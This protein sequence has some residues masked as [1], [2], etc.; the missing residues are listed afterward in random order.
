MQAAIRRILFLV[1]VLV[2]A[3]TLYALLPLLKEGWPTE[4]PLYTLG[5][6]AL[7]LALLVSWRRVHAGKP[8]AKGAGY[9]IGLALVGVPLLFYGFVGLMLAYRAALG[10]LFDR[11]VAITGYHT[12]LI[13]WDGFDGPVGVRLIVDIDVPFSMQGS[14]LEP[15]IGVAPT[16]EER[17]S[18]FRRYYQYC[19][20]P[21]PCLAAPRMPYRPATNNAPRLAR[22][23]LRVTYDLLPGSVA[24]LENPSRLCTKQESGDS[25]YPLKDSVRA[26]WLFASDGNVVIDLSDRLTERI[27]NDDAI[28]WTPTLLQAMY[29]QFD[30]KR[31]LRVGYRR[32]ELR[33]SSASC[34][35]R[36]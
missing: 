33:V 35:C 27:A 17:L 11:N 10:F 15:K 23:P 12:S 36:P 24:Y 18:P 2:S 32:C 34:Y 16:V 7:L 26:S 13:R 4:S 20:S 21:Y 14:F 31:L 29:R 28:T 6:V 9:T 8:T 19:G 30:E 22:G 5:V 25:T 1:I 3:L